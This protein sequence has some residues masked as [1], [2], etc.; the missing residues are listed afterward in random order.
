MKCRGMPL[1]RM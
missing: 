1:C